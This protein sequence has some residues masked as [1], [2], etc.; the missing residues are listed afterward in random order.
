M[1]WDVTGVSALLMIG[2]QGL[3]KQL[4]NTWPPKVLG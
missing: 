4:Q 3:S 2:M 1:P